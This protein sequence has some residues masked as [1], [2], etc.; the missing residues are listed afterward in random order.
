MHTPN[1]FEFDPAQIV[2]LLN[3][4][5]FGQQEAS[6]IIGDQLRMV[7]NGFV[8]SNR[9]LS[10]LLLMGGPGVGKNETIRRLAHAICGNAAAV[11]WIE[12]ADF[13][14]LL[15]AAPGITVEQVFP[16]AKLAGQPKSPSIVAFKQ[17]ETADPTA[18]AGMREILTTGKLTI[19]GVKEQISFT[20]ALIFLTTDLQ[21]GQQ[22]SYKTFP[23]RFFARFKEPLI[24]N[25]LTSKLGG[26]FLSVIDALVPFNEINIEALPVLVDRALA[27]LAGKY[28]AKQIH[29]DFAPE[30]TH[31]IL[32]SPH[33]QL[34]AKA[35]LEQI[36][37]GKLEAPLR[38]WL[39][40]QQPLTTPMLVRVELA[41]PGR[42]A[43]IIRGKT[44]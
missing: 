43:F 38:S 29:L 21:A 5:F 9:P 8:S 25:S 1:F 42:V 19:P 37:S 22:F 14:Q 13:S 15:T 11:C 40:Q 12:L 10:S 33:D 4:H 3:Q 6:K 36:V 30:L 44:K 28:A 20:N 2:A 16:P 7:K 18:V 23:Q 26:D 17:I 27:N 34:D 41:G 35:G 39:R 31:F 32:T 24:S